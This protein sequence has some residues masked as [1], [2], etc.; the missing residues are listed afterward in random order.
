[1]HN[2]NL[3]RK[4]RY[5]CIVAHL[6]LTH[7]TVTP[8]WHSMTTTIVKSSRDLKQA[9]EI[10][11]HELTCYGCPEE[12]D[13]EDYYF[14]AGYGEVVLNALMINGIPAEIIVDR[15]EELEQDVWPHYKED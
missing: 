2:D 10:A 14:Y 9:M 11:E 15:T 4:E 6:T 3:I 13:D 12:S 5:V 8:T 7:S 1:M